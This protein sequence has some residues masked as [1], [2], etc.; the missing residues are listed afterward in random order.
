MSKYPMLTCHFQVEWG[1]TRVAFSE[2]TGL[3]IEYDVVEYHD[4]SSPEAGSV[5]M[6]GLRKNTNIT[7]K[8]G[9][10]KGD[11]EFFQWINTVSLN[12]VE[13]RDLTISLLD[14]THA[15][16]ML[17]KVKNAWPVKLESPLFNAH[18]SEVAIESL[19]LAH[20]GIRIETN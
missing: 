8:R 9:I 12:Q 5:K 15:P 13:R 11:N 14:E 3:S 17:W 6:P 19:E 2:V 18:A 7:L 1:G 16:V 20:E 10:V 4:G